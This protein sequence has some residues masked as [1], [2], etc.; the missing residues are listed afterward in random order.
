MTLD[1]TA[2]H[3]V[4]SAIMPLSRRYRMDRMHEVPR[5]R[6]AMST[7]AMDPRCKGVH[8]YKHCQVFRNKDIFAAAYPNE[9][10]SNC[11]AA[12]KQFISDYGAADSMITDGLK[13]QTGAGTEF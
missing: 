9:K 4:R 3:H 12:L 6:C 1:A 13:E 10:T 11:H 7:D 5:L 2:Q 8:G